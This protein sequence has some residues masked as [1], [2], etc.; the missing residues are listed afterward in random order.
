M[1][2]LILLSTVGPISIVI[3]LLVIGELSRRLGA[4]LKI[5]SVHR[6]F[7]L[8]AI[9]VCISVIIRFLSIGLPE[10]DFTT[11][12]DAIWAL[13]YTIPLTLGVIIGLVSAWRYWGWLVY[14]SDGKTLVPK[15]VKSKNNDR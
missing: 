10:E 4:V 6:W 7:Y 2:A 11:R 15:S 8:A 1:P 3:V 12:N 14:A 5:G 9:I 13:L